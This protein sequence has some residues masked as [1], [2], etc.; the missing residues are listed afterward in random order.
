MY[1]TLT[2]ASHILIV[3]S[4]LPPHSSVELTWT[5]L[6]TFEPSTS[7]TV[8]CVC[9][10]QKILIISLIIVLSSLIMVHYIHLKGYI[11]IRIYVA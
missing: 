5:I 9:N 1:M 7:P 10:K 3:V 8:W 2:S 11:W 6:F 4:E